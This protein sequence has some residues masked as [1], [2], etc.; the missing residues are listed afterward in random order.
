MLKANV[1]ITTNS[2]ESEVSGASVDVAG[3]LLALTMKIY[4]IIKDTD[5]RVARM[6]KLSLLSSLC[7][8]DE[9]R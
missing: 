8:A 7:D 9:V 5:P 6:L 4:R 3:E 1:D 2:V